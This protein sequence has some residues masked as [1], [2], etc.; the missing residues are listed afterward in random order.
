MCKV[1]KVVILC[2]RQH[3]SCLRQR[4]Q[5]WNHNWKILS[6]WNAVGCQEMLLSLKSF[7]GCPSLLLTTSLF[8]NILENSLRFIP[9]GGSSSFGHAPGMPF[10][11][12]ERSLHLRYSIIPKTKPWQRKLLSK[13]ISKRSSSFIIARSKVWSKQTYWL[14]NEM[15]W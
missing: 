11:E 7:E 5:H 9:H 13:S 6:T 10:T 2:L 14:S 1:F 4:H 8:G 15:I 12:S 3:L